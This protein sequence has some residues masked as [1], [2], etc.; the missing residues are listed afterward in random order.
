MKKDDD[1]DT[2]SSYMIFTHQLEKLCACVGVEMDLNNVQTTKENILAQLPV[3]L[4]L[5]MYKS[6]ISTFIR[7][8][9]KTT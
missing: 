7:K 9:E 3:T 6:K 8:I 4:E 2:H 5:E 1:S